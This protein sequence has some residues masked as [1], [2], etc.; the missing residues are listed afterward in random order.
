MD[1]AFQSF[2]ATF[3]QSFLLSIVASIYYPQ[4]AASF[5]TGHPKVQI[6]S[7]LPSP[8]EPF[9]RAS[10]PPP[11]PFVVRSSTLEKCHYFWAQL[12]TK[13]ACTRCYWTTACWL[14]EE[15]LGPWQHKSPRLH[16]ANCTRNCGTRPRAT[17][18]TDT[19]ISIA[20]LIS[21]WFS[22]LTATTIG[23]CSLHKHYN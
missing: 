16:C 23:K 15:S 9:F 3:L 12:P 14:F 1:N 8:P 21:K 10:F 22:L 5:C 6:N 20:V 13:T 4:H 7:L 2:V 17:G 11:P 19:H 18:V